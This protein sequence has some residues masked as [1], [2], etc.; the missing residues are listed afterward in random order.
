MKQ[1]E[2]LETVP[3]WQ[4]APAGSY[5]LETSAQNKQVV[6]FVSTPSARDIYNNVK[7]HWGLGE[8]IVV[9]FFDEIGMRY[10]L[11]ISSIT[12]VDHAI[13][14]ESLRIT[15]ITG[16]TYNDLDEITGTDE[17]LLPY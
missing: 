3:V 16:S 7:D 5:P 17:D 10:Y 2:I 11:P 1:V 12:I 9:S 14:G 6:T 13:L 15:A 4:E 8:D